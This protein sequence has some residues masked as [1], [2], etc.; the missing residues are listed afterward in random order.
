MATHAAG[1]ENRVRDHRAR[2]GWSQGELARRAGLS[3]AGV[4]AIERGRL[5]PSAAAALALAA[6]FGAKVEDLFSLPHAATEPPAWAWDP[7]ATGAP[8]RYWRAEV[9]GRSRLYPAE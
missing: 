8:V 6:A 9:G 1:L 2:R 4:S 7:P 3:R 5:V